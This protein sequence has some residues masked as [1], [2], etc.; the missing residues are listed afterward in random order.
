MEVE[1]VEWEHQP[2]LDGFESQYAEQPVGEIDTPLK[3]KPV[4]PVCLKF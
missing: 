4:L 1:A 2:A 3:L